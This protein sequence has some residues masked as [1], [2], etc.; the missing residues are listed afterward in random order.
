MTLD[1]ISEHVVHRI[2][3]TKDSRE[4]S[5]SEQLSLYN[6]RERENYL[7]NERQEYIDKLPH[8]D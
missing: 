6:P 3:G 5:S 4:S 8:T 7:E 2:F 1:N